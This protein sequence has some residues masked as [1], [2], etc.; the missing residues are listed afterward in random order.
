ML[1]VM[2][3][4]GVTWGPGLIVFGLLTPLWLPVPFVVTVLRGDANAWTLASVV[5]FAVI[6][7]MTYRLLRRPR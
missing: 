2:Y 4:E 6:F 3:P 7:V 5:T 1:A